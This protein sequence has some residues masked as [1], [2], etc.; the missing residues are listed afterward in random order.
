M[1]FYWQ[2]RFAPMH[3]TRVVTLMIAAVSG[4]LF[5]QEPSLAGRVLDST[6]AV[7][8]GVTVEAVPTLGGDLQ[9]AVSGLDGTYSI[10]LAPGTYFHPVEKRAFRVGVTTSF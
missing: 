10:A 5:A 3:L 2:C 7:L 6:N 9:P 1:N 8:P 4:G